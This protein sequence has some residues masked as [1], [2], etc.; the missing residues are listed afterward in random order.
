MSATPVTLLTGF[1]GAGKT[2]LLN[3]L[4][5]RP[6]LSRSAVIINEFGQIGIDH[7]L[8][9]AVQ[10]DLLVLTTGCICC[11]ARGHLVDAMHDLLARR[12]DGC[13]AFDRIVVETT[14]LADP[15][16]VLQALAVDEV[17]RRA[18]RV[19]AVVAVVDALSGA[20]TLA[21]HAEARSQV[22]LAD[23]IVLSKTDLVDGADRSSALDDTLRRLNPAAILLM[24]QDRR[25]V[26]SALGGPASPVPDR[27]GAT[28][29]SP[30]HRHHDAV[31]VCL[32]AGSVAPDLF[33]AFIARLFARHGDA[34]LRLKGIVASLD[35]P[36]R[37]IV[38]QAAGTS[39]SPAVRLPHW[40]GAE[41]GTRVVVIVRGV[42]PAAI[43][44]Q[45]DAFLGPPAID[46]P[47]AAGLA[48]WSSNT[49]GLF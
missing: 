20:V 46:R 44:D 29:A 21:A 36:E 43:R 35:D 24:G 40:S 15:A 39:L 41:R 31:A 22:A 28:A 1:L 25:A 12:H 10:G 9:E 6:E 17:L 2:T 45:W 42:P 23:V 33:E 30:T 4:L 5:A 37:P 3:A 47:D 48:P 27:V 14:G 34:V 26:A 7:L 13:I 18:C 32:K 8:V 16:P 38:V 11:T 49:P 19:D